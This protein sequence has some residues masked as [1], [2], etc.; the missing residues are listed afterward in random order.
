MMILTM[1]KWK[2]LLPFVLMFVFALTRW[3]GL[4]PPNFSAAYALAFCAGVYFGGG[5]AWFLPLGTLFLSD[6]FLCLHYEYPLQTYQIFNY[7]AYLIIIGTGRCIGEKASMARLLLGTMFGA[8]MFYLITNSAAWFFNPFKN[9]EYT[10]D[11]DGWIVALTKGTANF[12]QTWEF[13]RNT[14]MS[15]ALFTALFAGTMK[16]SQAFE[17][18]KSRAESNA[19][20]M[21]NQKQLP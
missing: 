12:P 8:V 16:L 2:S 18:A 6:L 20:Q 3:P 7:L 14:L 19:T 1:F 10:K 17:D 9:P 11:L 4:L 15:S 13:L 21:Q 5:M